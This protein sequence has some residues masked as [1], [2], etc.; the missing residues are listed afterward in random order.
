MLC[1]RCVTQAD[2]VAG[3]RSV[4]VTIQLALERKQSRGAQGADPQAACETCEAAAAARRALR[5]KFI[6]RVES[7]GIPLYWP[8]AD[9][10]RC[11]QP[12]SLPR[13][14]TRT[15]SPTLD[16]WITHAA[17]MARAITFNL[18][19]LFL[20]CSFRDRRFC[21]IL[22]LYLEIAGTSW[23]IQCEKCGRSQV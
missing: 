1:N 23:K 4:L 16:W 3:R 15:P 12:R 2:Q 18:R 11:H 13:P 9:L 5:T 6:R 19:M 17:L 7:S 22:A 8:V 10:E 14:A 21:I 20:D